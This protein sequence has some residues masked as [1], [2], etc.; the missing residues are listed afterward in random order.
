MSASV[1]LARGPGE[2]AH[3]ESLSRV[4]LSLDEVRAAGRPAFFVDWGEALLF[5]DGQLFEVRD[6]AAAR[7]AGGRPEPLPAQVLE[8][9]VGIE[10]GWR[11]SA[12]CDCRACQARRITPQ[13]RAWRPS[14]AAAAVPGGAAGVAGEAPAVTSEAAA[15]PG[16]R[17]SAARTAGSAQR[18]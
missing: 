8:A 17:A 2:T 16:V 10:Y 6:L 7:R 13:A 14:A 12:G 11:H 1:E 9:G 18:R 3:L 5:D 15:G 4:V